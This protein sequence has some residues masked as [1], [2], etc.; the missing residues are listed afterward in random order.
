MVLKRDEQNNQ[1][2]RFTRRKEKEGDDFLVF[3][4]VI[5]FF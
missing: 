3:F 2:T 1:P 5:L 4:A